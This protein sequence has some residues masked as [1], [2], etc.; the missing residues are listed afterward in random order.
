[1]TFYQI[2]TGVLPL[3]GDYKIINIQAPDLP[4]EFTEY[5]ALFKK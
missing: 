1:M 2:L 4:N 5:N 3:V